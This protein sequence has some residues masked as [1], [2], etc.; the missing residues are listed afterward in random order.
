[1][2]GSITFGKE[3]LT[4]NLLLLP[5]S[6]PLNLMTLELLEAMYVAGLCDIHKMAA[7]GCTAES[8]EENDVAVSGIALEVEMCSESRSLRHCL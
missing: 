3:L 8:V 6:S 4:D 1:M 7:T 5:D 2:Q